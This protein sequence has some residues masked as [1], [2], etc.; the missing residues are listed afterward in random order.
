MAMPVDSTEF[1][2]IPEKSASNSQSKI[3][4]TPLLLFF[5]NIQYTYTQSVGQTKGFLQINLQLLLR[6]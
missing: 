4:T 5:K 3:S 6:K 1:K 2:K